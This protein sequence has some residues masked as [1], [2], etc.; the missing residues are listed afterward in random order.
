[1]A[2]KQGEDLLFPE[3]KPG[4]LDDK[5]SSAAVKAYGRYRRACEVPDGTDFHSYRRNVCTVLENAG[6]GQ[7]PIARYVGQKV[8]TMAG[9]TYS[10]GS[11]KENSIKTSKKVRYGTDVEAAALLLAKVP[12]GHSV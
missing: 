7:V 5:L 8:G 3:L 6:V 2:G 11:A 4:G 9:D 1:M 10:G 12:I